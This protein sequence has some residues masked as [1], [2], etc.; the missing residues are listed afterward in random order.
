[1]V[2]ASFYDRRQHLIELE[3]GA[4]LLCNG[5]PVARKSVLFVGTVRAPAA[6]APT[7]FELHRAGPDEVARV[8]IGPP[9]QLRITS[10]AEPAQIGY[11]LALSWSPAGGTGSVDIDLQ[12]ECIERGHWPSIP[13]TGRALVGPI[14][15]V[16]V[17]APACS[18]SVLVVRTDPVVV[19]SVFATAQA[20]R[21]AAVVQTLPIHP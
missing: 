17:G 3:P 16:R 20:W 2:G 11:P 10:P 9:P 8:E 14:R 5:E 7:V 15:P 12:G 4:E 19:E 1:L 13:D 6:D 18:G 21:D